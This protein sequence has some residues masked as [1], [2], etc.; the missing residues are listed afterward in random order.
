MIVVDVKERSDGTREL[1]V[2]CHC[3]RRIKLKFLSPVVIEQN[4]RYQ[5]RGESAN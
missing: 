1:E 4:V 2:K 5:L 3:G